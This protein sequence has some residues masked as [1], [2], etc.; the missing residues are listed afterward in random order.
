MEHTVHVKVA[1]QCRS[2]IKYGCLQMTLRLTCS[3]GLLV[4]ARGEQR[5]H[6]VY[7]VRC[8]SLH[9]QHSRACTPLAMTQAVQHGREASADLSQENLWQLGM[10]ACGAEEQP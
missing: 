1:T 10:A 4:P 5:A 3:I 8:T 6:P 2:A 7:A 9:A